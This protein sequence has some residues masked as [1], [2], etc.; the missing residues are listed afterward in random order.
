MN[1]DLEVGGLLKVVFIPNYCI[2][3]AE[4]II[5]ANEYILTYFKD[6]KVS[7]GQGRLQGEVS[8]D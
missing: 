1:N 4:V 6:G 7:D 8:L 5:P 3:L 2:S